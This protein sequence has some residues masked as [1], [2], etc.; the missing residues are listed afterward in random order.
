MISREIFKR[1][2]GWKYAT[3]EEFNAAYDRRVRNAEGIMLTEEEFIIE[4][5]E[6]YYDPEML[7]QVYANLVRLVDAGKLSSAEILAYAV[8]KWCLRD[9]EALVAYQGSRDIWHVNNCGTSVREDK[10]IIEV[11]CEWG[12]EASRI[13]IIGTPYYDATDYQFIRFDCAHMSWLWK[14]GSLFFVYA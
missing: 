4:A 11:N 3:E 2:Y 12:F 8:Y 6:Q 10:A 13:K 7:K 14:N 5:D 9:A 1:D